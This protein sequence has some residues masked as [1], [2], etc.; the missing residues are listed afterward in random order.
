MNRSCSFSKA[1]IGISGRS[2]SSFTATDNFFAFWFRF[3]FLNKSLLE[4]G[5]IDFILA[6]IKKDLTLFLGRIY[7]E[8]LPDI[9][10]QAMRAQRV[11]FYFPHVGRWWLGNAEIDWVALN[12]EDKSILFGEAKWTTKPVGTN[13]FEELLAKSEQVEWQNKK[14][15]AF[16]ALFSKSGFTSAMMEMAKSRGF[17]FF[18]AK[19]S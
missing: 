16:F 19:R 15:K 12:P 18:M 3:I 8:A 9:V 13:I 17:Y 10:H 5:Q 11:P 4:E 6:K 14:R 1:N 2:L 7:E